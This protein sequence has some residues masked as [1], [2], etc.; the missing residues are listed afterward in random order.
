MRMSVRGFAVVLSAAVLAACNAMGGGPSAAATASVAQAARVGPV[1]DTGT[2]E[3]A[4]YRIDI[5][6]DWNGELVVNAHGY[7]V[8]GS[9]A[10]PME[11][12]G[13][14]QPLLDRGFAVASSDYSAQGWAIAEAVA[15]TERLRAHFVARH[16]APRRSWLVGWSMGGL[17]A[18]A[19]AERHP[20]GWDGVV[21]MCAV[22]TPTE[23]MFARAALAP[24]AAFDALYPGVLPQAP[25]GLADA[26]LPDMPDGDAIEA[27]LAADEARA[28]AFSRRFDLPRADAASSLW[29][30]YVA[31]RE[32]ATRAGGFP[33]A[34]T[35]GAGGTDGDEAALGVR[36]RRYVADPA[37]L[38]YVRRT[39]ALTGAAPVPV[40]LQPNAVDP[41]VT[42]SF[43]R[44]YAALAEAGGRGARVR[45]LPGVG[46]GHCRFPPETVATAL[47]TLRGR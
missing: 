3:G 2:L 40:V 32:L 35:T 10:R 12:P 20:R 34:S 4:P 11:V 39:G 14:M 15:D 7:V 41:I 44:G 27:A 21:A 18:L 22:A 42:A 1:V 29:L 9:P 36:I 33:V 23:T 19:S 17:V 28:A 46:E 8:A 24:L 26:A 6:T 47:E 45:T 5:P 16:G 31:L 30:Y 25:G 38:A 13:G 43:S 37:A